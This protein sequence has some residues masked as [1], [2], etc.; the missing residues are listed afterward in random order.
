MKISFLVRWLPPKID[1]V[2]DYTWNLVCAL[3]KQGID[4]DIFTSAEQEGHGLVNN[5]WVF[6]VIKKWDTDGI[7]NAFRGKSPDW[8]CLQYVPQSYGHGC[9]AWQVPQIISSLKRKSRSNIA[10]TFHEFIWG[11]G[12]WPKDLFLASI[13]RLQTRRMLLT[14][15]SAITTCVRYR[16]ILEKLA[17]RHLKINVIPVGSNIE[18]VFL[19]LEESKAIRKQIFPDSAKVLGLFSRLSQYRNFPLALKTL[20][21]ARDKGIDAWLYLVGNI[22]SSNPPMF[23]DLMRLAHKLGVKSHI[24]TTGV[25]PKEELSL[26]LKLIDV[27]IFPQSDGI[28]TRNTALM[29]AIAHGLPIVSFKPLPGNFDNFSIPCGVLV[30]RQ[31][32]KSFIQAAITC[33][34]DNTVSNSASTVN[35]DYYYN[36]FSWPIIAREYSQALRI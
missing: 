3:R 27:F 33:L 16:G 1:G 26:H 6:P 32:E 14:I 20:K 21:A 9:I 18:P 4:A 25:L 28:S 12:I 36:N 13:T 35:K 31:D 15:D 34:K 10:V 24:V 5:D 2:G 22:A 7:L 17:N 30:N 23:N 8:F 19:G 29:A 11:W